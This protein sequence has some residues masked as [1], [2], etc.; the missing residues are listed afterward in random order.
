M[1]EDPSTQP[2]S[3]PLST[4]R[5]IPRRDWGNPTPQFHLH[6]FP[7]TSFSPKRVL[8]IE[9]KTRA[10][11]RMV[12][13]WSPQPLFGQEETHKRNHRTGLSGPV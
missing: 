13:M 2:H 6:G 9:Q 11:P 8:L 10:L 1:S 7:T 3:E 12:V 5:Y 4:D